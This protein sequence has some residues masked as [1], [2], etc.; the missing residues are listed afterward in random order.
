M[1]KSKN[2]LL[3]GSLIF[4]GFILG[5]ITMRSITKG[6]NN[7][8]KDTSDL[9]ND[10]TKRMYKL[11]GSDSLFCG[12]GENYSGDGKSLERDKEIDVEIDD[13]ENYD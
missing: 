7:K 5:S 3:G 10:N 11:Y 1:G 4:A 13:Y 6:R 12:Y 9:D 2:F 8:N